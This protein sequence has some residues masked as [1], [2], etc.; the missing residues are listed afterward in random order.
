MLRTKYFQAVRNIA[1]MTTTPVEDAIRLKV[2]TV[3][4]LPEVFLGLTGPSRLMKH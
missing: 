3:D 2:G 4:C 1:T